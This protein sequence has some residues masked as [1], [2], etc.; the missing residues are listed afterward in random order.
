MTLPEAEGAPRP[1]GMWG[2]RC[3]P[4]PRPRAWS[5][6]LST[7][8]ACHQKPSAETYPTGANSRHHTLAP[9]P[10]GSDSG[11]AQGRQTAIPASASRPA[12]KVPQQAK[13]ALVTIK[14]AHKRKAAQRKSK[15]KQ[16][17]GFSVPRGIGSGIRSFL[18]EISYIS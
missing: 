15:T 3:P 7:A 10:Q 5:G 11:R 9:R 18:S 2:E 16:R 17:L 6:T 13:L 8:H 4:P 1:S 12:L 14:P